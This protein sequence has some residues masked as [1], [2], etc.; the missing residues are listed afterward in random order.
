[1]NKRPDWY[2]IFYYELSMIEF[3]CPFSWYFHTAAFKLGYKCYGDTRGLSNKYTGMVSFK[4]IDFQTCQTI[5]TH[6]SNW[7]ACTFAEVEASFRVYSLISS[8][9][10]SPLLFYRRKESCHPDVKTSEAPNENTAMLVL[11]VKKINTFNGQVASYYKFG[12]SKCF[13]FNKIGGGSSQCC[14]WI[15]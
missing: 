7:F 1:M 3:S 4:E 10:I 11:N 14:Q 2:L 15:I 9:I 6:S 5:C 13:A 8:F 12:V